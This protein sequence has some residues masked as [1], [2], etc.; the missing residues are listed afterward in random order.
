MS[1]SVFDHPWL[2]GLFE[3]PQIAP[4]WSAEAQLAHLLRY[5]RAW[6]AALQTT[7]RI[8]DQAA[9][10]AQQALDGWQPDWGDLK[11]G[12]G[13]DG[14]VVPALVRQMRQGL[15]TPAAIHSGATSQDVIDTG[16][17][18]TLQQVTARLCADLEV[19]LTQIDALIDRFGDRA[20]MGRTRMQAALPT[21]VRHRLMGWRGGVMRALEQAPE[22][23][24][25][26]QIGGAV[27][28]GQAL[29]AD[30]AAIASALAQSL[31]LPCPHRTWH[32][33]RST[34]VSYGAW[35]M[36]LTGALGKLGQDVCLMAQQGT[37]ELTLSAG[38]RSSAMPHKVNPVHAELLVTLAR[39]TAG[40]AGLLGQSLIHEQE[41][42]G[43][44]W[45]LEWM[46]LPP[47]TMAAGCATHRAGSLLGDIT[48]LGADPD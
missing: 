13:R 11:R 18:L 12:T 27:G 23:N 1:A 42:S 43:A 6:T 45:A 46:V 28:D 35:L 31:S 48:G 25:P 37:D 20:L 16:L 15:E 29:E 33:D 22:Q 39:Y 32:S 26:L 47:M 41:R 44:A 8:S 36:G 30:A 9:A 24:L 34:V 17:A 14:V 10:E 2:S 40:Q 19:L 4:L 21:R 5:E 38:G 7:G 3:A